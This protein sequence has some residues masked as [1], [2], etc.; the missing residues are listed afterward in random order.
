VVDVVE[1]PTTHIA[2]QA[3]DLSPFA[4]LSVSEIYSSHTLEHL[5]MPL[6]PPAESDLRNEVTECLSEWRRVLRVGGVLRVSVPDVAAIAGLIATSSASS[7]TTA[8][9]DRDGE[10]RPLSLSLRDRHVLMSI[11]YGG[12]DSAPNFHKGGFLYDLLRRLREEAGFCQVRRGGYFGL[13]EDTSE[14]SI[15]GEQLSINVVASRCSL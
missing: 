9:R 11:L 10:K 15:F 12:Q 3:L 4:D 7:S 13:F 8:D 14:M 2:A 1:S 6:F 5:S